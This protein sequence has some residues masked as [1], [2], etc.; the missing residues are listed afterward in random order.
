MTQTLSKTY[1]TPGLVFKAKP[2]SLGHQE[3]CRRYA[4]PVYTPDGAGI[5]RDEIPELLAEFGVWGG[6]FSYQDPLTGAMEVGSEFRGGYFNLDEQAREKGWSDEDKEVVARHMIQMLSKPWCQFTLYD[7]PKVGAPWP[8]YDETHH[9]KIVDLAQTLGLVS[10]ALLYEEQEKNRPSVVEG[11]RAAL[12]KQA[13]SVGEL[14]A[15]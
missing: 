12:A 2:K 11:L 15:E 3:I 14:V 10:E 8:T 4:A 9:S 13:D 5:V 6:E 1:Y 7:R